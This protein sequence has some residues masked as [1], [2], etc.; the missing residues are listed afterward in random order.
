MRN[1]SK[2]IIA[3]VTLAL[4]TAICVPEAFAQGRVSRP[5][6]QRTETTRKPAKKK[7]RQ[8]KP[9]TQ[10]Q[11][12]GSINGHEWVDLGLPSGLKWAACNV[13]ATSPEGYGDYFAWGETR[14]KGS[15]D[16]EN[17]LTYGKSVS[18][19]Q[20]E[21]IISG[22][23]VLNYSYDAAR[24]NWGSTWRMPTEAECQELADKCNWTWTTRGGENGYKVTGPNGNSIFLPA[25]GNRY[26]SSLDS[27]GEYGYYWSSSVYDGADNAFGLDFYSGYHGVDWNG[28][29]YGFSV[30]PVSE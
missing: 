17:S 22:S 7:Q 3:V 13:G 29:G 28:R 20:S 30:R 16:E 9:K 18:A 21:G 6:K 2:S 24:S 19:L 1:K 23:G 12:T 27:A 10:K 4:L 11:T 25:A 5:Q 26:G 8:S 15:Y 14:R